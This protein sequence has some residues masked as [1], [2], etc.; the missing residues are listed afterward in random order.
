MP[1]YNSEKYLER[2]VYSLINQT[3]KN[4]EIIFN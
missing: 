3:I 1:C 4:I 2:C